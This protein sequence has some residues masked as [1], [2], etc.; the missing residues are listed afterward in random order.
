VS[1]DAPIRLVEEK[2]L[3][4]VLRVQDELDA[5]Y[6]APA[7]P[8]WAR[9][10]GGAYVL[11]AGA[12]AVLVGVPETSVEDLIFF[13]LAAVAV[14]GIAVFVG[15]YLKA[16]QKRVVLQDTL[17]DL[18]EVEVGGEDESHAEPA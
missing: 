14:V 1:K 6:L 13:G 8:M 11:A 7:P 2:R 15:L 9:L 12:F 17:R 16:R 4:E 18:I 3:E 10:A 5:T